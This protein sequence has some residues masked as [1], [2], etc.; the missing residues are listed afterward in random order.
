MKRY[1]KVFDGLLF[2]HSIIFICYF[3][4]T[5]NVGRNS[6][7]K[8]PTCTIT[9]EIN[10]RYENFNDTKNDLIRT[11]VCSSYFYILELYQLKNDVTVTSF[12][13][14]MTFSEEDRIVIQYLGQNQNY[15]AKRFFRDF[16]IKDG[17]LMD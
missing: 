4:F 12:V 5:C 10:T 2:I 16:L 17:N 13:Y 15:R 8:I 14:N 9:R 1:C 11:T 7:F 3:S 6:F